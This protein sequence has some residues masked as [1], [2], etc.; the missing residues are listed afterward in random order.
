MMK[1]SLILG[2][3][4]IASF[5]LI[6]FLVFTV[7]AMAGANVGVIEFVLV[8]LVAVVGAVVATRRVQKSLQRNTK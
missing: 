8:S 3:T 7:I 2:L 6:G 5:A 1:S 4:F